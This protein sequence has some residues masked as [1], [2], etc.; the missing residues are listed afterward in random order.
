MRAFPNIR[1]GWDCSP[2]V[3]RLR[4]TPRRRP[5]TRLF[6]PFLRETEGEFGCGSPIAYVSLR[7]NR[8]Q[9]K[10]AARRRYG[11]RHAGFAGNRVRR[12]AQVCEKREEDLCSLDRESRPE[13][14]APAGA[15]AGRNAGQLRSGVRNAVRSRK[16]ME[17]VQVSIHDANYAAALR[18]LLE[19]GGGRNVTCVERPDPALEG[20]IVVD[21]HTLDE[22]PVP[23]QRPE[24]VVL[25]ARNDPADLA[26]AWNAGIR[27]VVFSDDP[28][29]TAALAVMAAGLRI[30][31]Y[32]A[33]MGQARAEMRAS[34]QEK[35]R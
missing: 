4:R 11:T 7:S 6:L 35:L 22:L 3:R 29:G 16:P 31:K 13:G 17:K 5:S 32:V 30:P 25:I 14:I 34:G 33:A 2:Y 19:R 10:A 15:A 21:C 24:R 18:E 8:E 23:L 9:A 12:Q 1:P 28:L 26:R 27:S 20:V